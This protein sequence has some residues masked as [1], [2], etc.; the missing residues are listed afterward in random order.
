MGIQLG[1]QWLLVDQH[2]WQ[3]VRDAWNTEW[4]ACFHSLS[5]KVLEFLLVSVYEQQLADCSKVSTD[6]GANSS[7]WLLHTC[8]IHGEVCECRTFPL[9]VSHCL[10]L[11]SMRLH[12]S[13]AA[14]AKALPLLVV[15]V[16]QCSVGIGT[17]ANKQVC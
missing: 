9:D 10:S 1:R 14:Q 4:A 7:L 17:V 15:F 8:S 6:Q 12:L 2:N 5:C 13:W 11:A 3:R 16:W